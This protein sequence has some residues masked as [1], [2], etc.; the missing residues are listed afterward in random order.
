ME[1]KIKIFFVNA[2]SI[3]NLTINGC[4][5]ATPS[6]TRY[7]IKGYGFRFKKMKTI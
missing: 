5:Y 1:R 6:F 2:V 7:L 3:N 4:N